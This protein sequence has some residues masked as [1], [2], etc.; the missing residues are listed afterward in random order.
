MNVRYWLVHPRRFL[1]RLWHY[2]YEKAHPEEPFLAP[3]AVRFLDDALPR[4]GVGLEWGSGRSTRWLA[5][6]LGRL[7]TVEHDP[8]WFAAVSG[9]L[10]QAALANVDYRLLALEHPIDEPTRPLYEPMPRYVAFVDE[11]PDG[12]FDFI[13]VDGHYRQACVVKGWPKLKPGGL[14]LVDDTNW[15]PL[16][17]W[18]VPATWRLVHQSVKINTVTSIWQRPS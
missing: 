10:E 3:A 5:R 18:G 12:Y 9:Q 2:A 16:E 15:L 13:E 8:T 14:L 11:F 4:D 6:R 7:V 1:R 17:A